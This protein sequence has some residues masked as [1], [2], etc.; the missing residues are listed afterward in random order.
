MKN[1][2]VALSFVALFFLLI[3]S[4]TTKAQLHIGAEA[5]AT[6]SS[7][8]STPSYPEIYSPRVGVRGGLFVENE[9]NSFFALRTGLFYSLKGARAK[10]AD[11]FYWNI[12]CLTVPLMATFTPVKPIRLGIGLETS[13]F[14]SNNHQFMKLPVVGLGAKGEI[15]WQINKMF[16]LIGHVTYNFTSIM[17]VYYT[18]DQGNITNNGNPIP[19]NLIEGGLSLACT[20][21]TFEKKKTN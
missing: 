17:E 3:N 4:F 18:D 8:I 19:Y 9:F 15:A 2:H 11:L 13:V 16:R 6:I 21:K 20:I 12:H 1:Q 7:V 14:L 5:G 10:T